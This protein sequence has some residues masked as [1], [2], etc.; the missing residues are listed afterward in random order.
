MATATR[1]TML[2]SYA[3]PISVWR[4]D[5]HASAEARVPHR[6]STASTRTGSRQ[7]DAI[8]SSTENVG[9]PSSAKARTHAPAAYPSVGSP[10][11]DKTVST[12]RHLRRKSRYGSEAAD[13]RRPETVWALECRRRGMALTRCLRCGRVSSSRRANFLSSVMTPTARVGTTPWPSPRW[14]DRFRSW[15]CRSMC[16]PRHCLGQWPPTSRL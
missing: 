10:F 16:L 8:H 5:M 1:R 14:R 9:S 4:S 11:I 2:W 6:R 15:G 12:W 7:P 13:C 3:A